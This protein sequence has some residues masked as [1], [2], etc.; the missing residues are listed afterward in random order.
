MWGLKT[1]L[2][3]VVERESL[4]GVGAVLIHFDY[5][6]TVL[7]PSSCHNVRLGESHACSV[8]QL[9]QAIISAIF[10]HRWKKTMTSP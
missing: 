2:V 8:V 3:N 5:E 4:C 1:S 9:F 10:L 7:M 6:S